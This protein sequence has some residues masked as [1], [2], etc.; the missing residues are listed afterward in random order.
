[1]AFDFGDAM[2]SE[3]RSSGP[4]MFKDKNHMNLKVNDR[5][6]LNFVILPAFPEHDG[7]LTPDDKATSYA[8]AVELN[9][10]NIP[11]FSDWVA[12]IPTSHSFR[13][14]YY[15]V[16]SRYAIREYDDTGHRVHQED[17]ISKVIA[18]CNQFK[19]EWGYLTLE[20]FNAPKEQRP[21][22][23]PI[24]NEY[25]MNVLMLNGDKPG[26][27]LL[28]TTS[29]S[30]I[31]DLVRKPKDGA[32]NSRGIAWRQAQTRPTDEQIAADPSCVF[33]LGDITDPNSA[34]VFKCYKSDGTDG[35]KKNAYRIQPSYVTDAQGWN[36]VERM[37]L[38]TDIL[39]ARFDLGHPDT[40]IN[41]PTPE[42]QVK[43]I[44]GMLDGR[45]E[46][47]VHEL[48]MLRAAIPDYAELI[49]DVP[50]A[51]GAVNQVQGY[52]VNDSGQAQAKPQVQTQ[53][54]PAAKP[55][56][57]RFAPA[58][59][60]KQAQPA[61]QTQ[62]QPRFAPAGARPAAQPQQRFAPAGSKQAAQAQPQ[63]QSTAPKFVPR[64][65]PTQ[66][67]PQPKPQPKTQPQPQPQDNDAEE[68]FAPEVPG[69]AGDFDQEDWVAKYNAQN[70]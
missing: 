20:V 28:V 54:Q 26:P 37:P 63:A 59:A 16:V 46:E 48:D 9:E 11:I 68:P 44:V 29:M 17:P 67:K 30:A 69:E 64:A 62:A 58:G 12:A 56:Q 32:N 14:G 21:K 27:T 60:V 49:P 57:Q 10:D 45:N 41:I 34:V 36:S 15:P 3:Q 51:P 61:T 40:F 1:M 19:D 24:R 23:P 65:T 53:A 47:G 39:S 38:T 4:F 35:A 5:Q 18:Y 43:Q 6:V 25:M 22:L 8:R 13:P 52:S 42:E 2:G 55:Q 7:E 70:A 66:A 33:E 31:L 50:P